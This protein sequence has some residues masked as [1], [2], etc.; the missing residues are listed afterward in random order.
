MIRPSLALAICAFAVS[1]SNSGTPAKTT[2]SVGT[3][4][5]QVTGSDGTSLTIPAGAVTGDTTFT[6]ETAKNAAAPTGAA[7]VAAIY[8]FGPEGA[9]FAKPVTVTLPIDT[10]RLP[11]GKTAAD[12][13]IY[14]APT[15]S[16]T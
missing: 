10:S 11:A 3:S 9:Q 16:P 7:P 14:T 13:K 5:G 4:G 12:V 15:G 1:C 8:A 2:Q 6:I